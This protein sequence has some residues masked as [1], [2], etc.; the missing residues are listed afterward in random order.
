MKRAGFLIFLIIFLVSGNLLFYSQVTKDNANE[1]A[2]YYSYE[3]YRIFNELYYLI[4]TNKYIDKTVY[5]TIDFIKKKIDRKELLLL[6]DHKNESNDIL[7]GAYFVAS[8][9]KPEKNKPYILFNK[10]LIE[11]FNYQK[12]IV[13]S[14]FIHEIKHAYDYYTNYGLFKVTD[15]NMLEKYMFQMD[16]LYIEA[17]L[18]EKYLVPNNFNLTDFEKILLNSH[19][20]N[21][22]YDYSLIFELT[23]MKLVY[24]LYNLVMDKNTY[25]DNFK[26]ITDIGKILIDGFEDIN[27]EQDEWVKFRKLIAV[28]SYI[29]YINQITYNIINTKYKKMPPEEFNLNDYSPELFEINNTISNMITPNIEFIFKYNEKYYNKIEKIYNKYLEEITKPEYFIF[30]REFRF[31]HLV[32][33]DMLKIKE[34]VKPYDFFGYMEK[35]PDVLSKKY[36]FIIKKSVKLYN[37]EKYEQAAKILEVA[38][39]NEP[40]NPFILNF[41]AKALY[42]FDNESSYKYYNKLIEILDNQETGEKYFKIKNRDKDLLEIKNE[43]L[44]DEI[45]EISIE[46]AKI[47][48]ENIL[49]DYW[50]TESYW[51]LGTL[52]LDRSDYLRGIYEITRSMVTKKDDYKLLKEQAYSYLCESFCFLEKPE[53]AKY[54]ADQVFKI[55][56]D[57]KYVLKF[58]D[59]LKD[60]K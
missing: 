43:K 38:V 25:E 2:L 5:N 1:I 53:L 48:K 10:N 56:P 44:R 57:N 55:N 32:P 7:T 31:L 33:N 60:K 42:W 21:N 8:F 50:F 4:S 9:F 3:P 14:M 18:L 13:F 23:D 47:S 52:Y 29:N 26:S 39:K 28:Y 11:I 16:A 58:L 34:N 30:N 41:Y 54:C 6:V 22:L 20:K 27:K 40:D 35:M 37:E 59:M 49:V 24:Y 45:K 51:K 36:N 12:S 15:N 17:L 46:I 19:Q